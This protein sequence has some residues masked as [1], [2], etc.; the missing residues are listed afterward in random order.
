MSCYHPYAGCKKPDGTVRFLSGWKSYHELKMMEPS[1]FLIPCGHCIGCRMDYSRRWADR[2]MLELESN[3]G[4]GLFVTLTYDCRNVVNFLGEKI[5]VCK[6]PDLKDTGK[7]PNHDLCY[8]RCRHSGSLFKEHMQS[9]MKDLREDLRY[10]S[11]T[12][13][14]FYGVGEY[15]S[16]ENSHRPHM[17]LI[18]FGIGL[19]DLKNK[20]SAGFNELRQ[21]VYSDPLISR[22]WPYGSVCVG[23]VSWRT[24]AYVSRYVTKK[25]L[26]PSY[27]SILDM[28]GK[29]RMFSLMSRRPG[30]GKYYLDSH[31]DCLDNEYIYVSSEKGALKISIPRYYVNT[32]KLTDEAR[33]ANIIAQ[34][35]VYAEDSLLSKLNST[36]LDIF[37]YLQVEEDQ[38]VAKIKSLKRSI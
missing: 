4:K 25:A 9:F 16:F 1:A 11:G 2:M 21:A 26:D 35:A 3:S 29:N 20:V 33:Y 15:G 10:H 38:M 27:D 14:R 19:D 17:H 24:C 5:C 6:Y 36:D 18:L 28:L 7:C 30:I 8:E 31:P 37:S 23:D 12:K 34:R 13:I 32:L 22:H